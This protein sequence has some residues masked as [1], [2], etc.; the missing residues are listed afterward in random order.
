M[1]PIYWIDDLP[2]PLDTVADVEELMDMVRVRKEEPQGSARKSL[3]EL[4][5]A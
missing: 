3:K 1:E 2:E 4:N 5:P